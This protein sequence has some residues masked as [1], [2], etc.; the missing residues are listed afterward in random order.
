[1]DFRI[2]GPLEVVRDDGT[3]AECTPRQ[4]SLL[5]LLLIAAGRPVSTDSIVAKLW[6][7]TPPASIDSA[8]HFH[9]AKLRQTLQPGVTANESVIFTRPPGYGITIGHNEF[10]VATFER[11]VAAAAAVAESQAETAAGILRDALDLWRG[12]ALHDFAYQEFAQ[13][14]IARL[15]ELKLTAIEALIDADFASGKHAVLV[16]EL[17]K[18]VQ[19]YPLR[20]GLWQRLMLALYRSGRQGEALRSYRRVKDLLGEELGIEPSAGLTALEERMLLQDPGLDHHVRSPSNLPASVTPFVGRAEELTRLVGLIGDSRLVSIKGLGGVGKTRLALEMG[21]RTQDDF[22]DGVWFVDLSGVDQDSAVNREIE[23]SLGLPEVEGASALDTVA[24]WVGDHDLLLILDNCEQVRA[25]VSDAAEGL[26]SACGALRILMTTR[27]R[28]GGPAEL[29]FELDGLAA[30]E[31]GA[32][33]KDVLLATDAGRLI[34]QRASA[35]RSDILDSRSNADELAA[36]CR[37]LDGLPLALELAAA[38]MRIMSPAEVRARLDDRFPLLRDAK[39][40]GSARHRSLRNAL[41][42]SYDLLDGSAAAMFSTLAVFS[43]GWTFAAAVQVAGIDEFE[44]DQALEDLVDASLVAM[45]PTPAAT[46]Y[47]MLETVRQYALEQVE[48]ERAQQVR[49]H[50]LDYYVQLASMSRSEFAG[51]GQ[52]DALERLQTESANLRVALASAR[53]LEDRKSELSLVANLGRFWFDAGYVNEG[54]SEL[55]T[56]LAFWTDDPTPELAKALEE[57]V[58]LYAWDGS[59]DLA[60]QFAERH[61]SIVSAIG[62]DEAL[63]RS[64]GTKGI[65]AFIKGDYGG[66]IG[67]LDHMLPLI[68]AVGGDSL[69]FVHADLAYLHL[70]SGKPQVAEEHFE[71]SVRWIGEFGLDEGAAIVDDFGGWRSFYLG[72]HAEAITQWSAAEAIYE[73]LQ[74]RTWVVDMRQLQ[75]WVAIIDGVPNPDLLASSIE[76]A[77]RLGLKSFVARGKMLTAVVEDSGAMLRE[78]LSDAAGAGC[79]V[80]VFYCLWYGAKRAVEAAELSEAKQLRRW[81]ETFRRAIPLSLPV[82]LATQD[83]GLRAALGSVRPAN[84]GVA[85]APLE[86]LAL[87]IPD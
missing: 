57:I 27:E 76:E 37:D 15:E 32:T 50:H 66:A 67:Y 61:S 56:T 31:P 78:A 47:K 79:Q 1:M 3:L 59:I 60:E 25:G 87:L 85:N 65:L 39:R 43:G 69:P 46:R 44:V 8:I 84:A 41:E 26:L 52:R 71:Q 14:E 82:A 80:W 11:L 70:W 34:A 68:E 4:R 64:L 33:G 75:S 62:T 81:V 55:A 12:P 58:Q 36:I 24:A 54:L 51:S 48:P 83:A 45:Q 53:E 63:S 42:W 22:T 77:E 49:A 74:H 10:D 35:V 86:E 16:G 19:D 6:G 13:S 18:L 9:I 7:E 23:L 28:I 40:P 38:R 72:T 2:L 73:D 5:G 17:E 30:P 21:R 20:E 29:I